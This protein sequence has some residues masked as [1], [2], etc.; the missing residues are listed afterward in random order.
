M[1][2]DLNDDQRL[3]ADSVG[4]LMTERG[5]F[6]ARAAVLREGRGWNRA[7]WRDMADLG[8]LGLAFAEGDGGLGGGGVETMVVAEAL[9]RGLSLE[10]WLATVVLAG[11]ALRRGAS[12][13]QRASRIPAIIAGERIMALAYAEPNA[14]RHTLHVTRTSATY[15]GAGWTLTGAKIAV[16]HGADADELVVSA[17]T[18]A[19]LA[20]FLVDAAA[21]GVVRDGV[22][23]YDGIPVAAIRFDGA[24][25]EPLAGDVAAHD[26]LAAVTDDAIAALCAEAVGVMAE[27]IDLTAEYLKTR[28]QF[29]TPLGAFQALQHRLVDMLI[30]V[31]LSRSIAIHAALAVDASSSTAERALNVSAAKAQIGRAG[32]MVGQSAVQLHGAIGFTSEYKVG[33]LFKRLTAIDALFGDADHHLTRI[34]AARGLPELA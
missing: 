11:G 22:T 7:L 34:A 17:A 24:P 12:A 3:L 26:V 30:Q 19:G 27:T 20:L 4:R 9:G 2:F 23:G 21:P 18:D 25:A 16:L 33:H 29:G 31:E 14:P 15:G 10:P 32:R 1:D 6:E 13:E 8:V 5:G 28:Q